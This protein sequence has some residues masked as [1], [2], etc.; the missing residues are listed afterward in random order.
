MWR[1]HELMWTF[2]A[3]PELRF[4]E[5]YVHLVDAFSFLMLITFFISHAHAVYT[6]FMAHHG[7]EVTKHFHLPTAWQATFSHGVGGRTVGINSEVF[8]T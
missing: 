5:L 4:E 6:E 7:F 8:L 2:V 1:Q 3:H